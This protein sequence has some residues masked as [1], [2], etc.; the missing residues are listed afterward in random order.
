MKVISFC[1]QKGGVGKTSSALALASGLAKK[2]Y[3]VLLI[4]L[5]PHRSGSSMQC[6]HSFR[7]GRP[8]DGE[9]SLQCFSG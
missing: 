4:D 5:D 3:K 8:D 2:D 1:N 9:N 7:S 6:F